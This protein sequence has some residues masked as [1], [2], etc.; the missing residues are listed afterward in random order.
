MCSLLQCVFKS[1]YM[2]SHCGSVFIEAF[3]QC[4]HDA[5]WGKRAGRSVQCCVSFVLRRTC[6]WCVKGKR[7]QECRETTR[8]VCVTSFRGLKESRLNVLWL[9]LWG[10]QRGGSF[11][12]GA[13]LNDRLS[14]FV[15]LDCRQ[16]VNAAWETTQVLRVLFFSERGVWPPSPF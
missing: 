12:W 2:H 4:S 8:R 1:M 16:A 7:A 11:C 15:T 5:F 9:I 3:L 14:V 13:L 10:E 6:A